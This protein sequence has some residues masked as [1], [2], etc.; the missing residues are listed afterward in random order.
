MSEQLREALSAIVDGEAS[1]FELRRVLDEI[2]KDESLQTTWQ[3]YHLMRSAMQGENTVN[4]GAMSD[5]IW[6]ELDFD[7]DV[8]QSDQPAL[9]IEATVAEQPT[10]RWGLALGSGAVAAAVATVLLVGGYLPGAGEDG[11]P[12]QVVQET[13]QE[14]GNVGQPNPLEL[15]VPDVDRERGLS[16]GVQNAEYVVTDAGAEFIRASDTDIGAP[17]D[18]DYGPGFISLSD[19]TPQ[20]RAH[21]EGRF[22]RHVQQRGMNNSNLLSF[23]KMITYEK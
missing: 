3:N 2:S 7:S 21:A 8:E 9:E 13:G 10:R 22:M 11:A 15:Q 4:V 23:T 6:A 17:A 20:Q 16:A 1:N 19:M 5:R 12:S 14:T 18:G